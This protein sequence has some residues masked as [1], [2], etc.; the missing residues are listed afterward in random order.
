MERAW[1]SNGDRSTLLKELEEPR[2]PS[3]APK[4][5]GM[6]TKRRL[7]ERGTEGRPARGSI[8]L[9]FLPH[10][11][12]SLAEECSQMATTALCRDTG[13][14]ELTSSA[15]HTW[16]PMS[17]AEISLATQG[18]GDAPLPPHSQQ[19]YLFHREPVD[20]GAFFRSLPTKEDLNT[21][22]D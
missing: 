17:L 16:P 7:K 5:P 6:S 20:I 19:D 14:G 21:E 3:T 11:T 9:V 12:Q 10:S 8:L 1:P 18:E 2:Q 13:E 4:H 15:A 22:E